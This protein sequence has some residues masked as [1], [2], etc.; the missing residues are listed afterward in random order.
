[1]L[2]KNFLFVTKLDNVVNILSPD[3]QWKN[4]NADARTVLLS[5]PAP[6]DRDT[7]LVAACVELQ[8]EITHTVS[9]T[10]NKT[11]QD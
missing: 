2:L 5:C 11:H 7:L 9:W 3:E 8:E 6:G 4:I 1:M 10:I